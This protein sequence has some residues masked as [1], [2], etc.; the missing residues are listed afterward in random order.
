MFS[1]AAIL[2]GNA[3][4]TTTSTTSTTTTTTTT[5][6]TKTTTTTTTSTAATT[7]AGSSSSGQKAAPSDQLAEILLR[8]AGSQSYYDIYKPDD[9]GDINNLQREFRGQFNLVLQCAKQLEGLS[10]ESEG[11]NSESD[12]DPVDQLKAS[13]EKMGSSIAK[14]KQMLVNTGCRLKSLEAANMGVALSEQEVIAV[15]KFYDNILDKK[16]NLDG[17]VA[18]FRMLDYVESLS[19]EK[20]EIDIYLEAV[21][22]IYGRILKPYKQETTIKIPRLVDPEAIEWD[23]DAVS[24]DIE[25]CGEASN[26]GLKARLSNKRG[27]FN[28]FPSYGEFEIP[29]FNVETGV[30]ESPRKKVSGWKPYSNQKHNERVYF[31]LDEGT[32][33][34]V[35]RYMFEKPPEDGGLVDDD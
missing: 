16:I 9:D 21:Q 30:E 12:D 3:I 5:T 34:L 22:Q 32:S 29:V 4:T 8:D 19:N 1:P 14:L 23:W 13:I 24:K 17:R 33:V 27:L 28:L 31:D 26:D 10:S 20:S 2:R 15:Q 25:E 6:T 35:S 7:S 18:T 11:S